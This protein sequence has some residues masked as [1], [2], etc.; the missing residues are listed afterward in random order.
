MT[1]LLVLD[2]TGFSLGGAAG[3][4][5]G[6]QL[7][8]EVALGGVYCFQAKLP[9]VVEG[10]CK[11]SG[12]EAARCRVAVPPTAMVAKV[13]AV[14]QMEAVLHAAE[15]PVGGFLVAAL[16]AVPVGHR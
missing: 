11:C 14:G 15:P 2:P 16:E 4:C 9:L 8:V 13:A 12:K 6:A 10:A 7:W 1:D 3:I 5:Q